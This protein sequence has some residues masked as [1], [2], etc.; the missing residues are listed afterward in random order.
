MSQQLKRLEEVRQLTT[1]LAL[2][3]ELTARIAAIQARLGRFEEAK[4]AVKALRKDHGDWRSGRIHVWIMFS[5]AI[6]DWYANLSY[7]ALDRITR[8]QLLS[9]AMKYAE[10]YA[11]ASAWKAHI[12]F[13]TSDF[14]GMF[15]SIATAIESRIK[16]NAD[17]N[18]RLAIVLSSAFALCGDSVNA[19]NWFMKGR[20][21]SL[22][23]GDQASV[24]ALQ[25][26]RAVLSLTCMRAD[27]CTNAID[28]DRL[29]IVRREI[30]S[31]RNLQL[32]TRIST[33]ANHLYLAEARLLILEGEYEKAIIA[34]ESVRNE[35]PFAA[36]H[37]NQCAIDL[38]IS[39]CRFL[40]DEREGAFGLFSS[41]DLSSLADLDVDDQLMASRILFEMARVDARFGNVNEIEERKA[42]LLIA[43][44]TSRSELAVG[45]Q[46]FAGVRLLD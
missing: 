33:L 34:L 24:E 22:T 35:A 9:G 5:E 42:V 20:S 13:E 39:Y 28:Q 29:R 2:V 44:L 27:S 1:D 45:L 4:A 12:Q 30:N 43:Y 23:E 38:E 37:F 15:R 21:L 16:E 11:I 40:L 7:Q 8:V 25:Y 6:I 32:L 18:I 41:I 10:M 19:Q 3:V 31:S 17:A 46:P 14:N 26:N 36:Y